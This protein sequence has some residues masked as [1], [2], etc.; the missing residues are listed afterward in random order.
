[1]AAAISS[2]LAGCSIG[3]NTCTP[4]A[5]LVLTAPGEPGVGKRPAHQLR[6]AHD[7]V[8][9]GLRRRVEVE[10]EVCLGKAVCIGARERRVILDR[11]LVREPQ[12]RPRIVTERVRNIAL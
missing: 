5:P 7:G 10:H 6:D 4:L 3:T 9:P 1:M 11:A 12:Q 2:A 8:E